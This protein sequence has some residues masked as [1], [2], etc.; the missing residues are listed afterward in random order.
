MI[1]LRSCQM[2]ILD[3][4]AQLRILFAMRLCR[5]FNILLLGRGIVVVSADN[6]E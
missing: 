5:Y 1:R 4:T 3:S 2:A 6:R